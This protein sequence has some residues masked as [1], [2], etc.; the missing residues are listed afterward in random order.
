MRPV[1][2]VLWYE[3]GNIVCGDG[4]RFGELLISGSSRQLDT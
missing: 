1:T 2:K 4:V 3:R